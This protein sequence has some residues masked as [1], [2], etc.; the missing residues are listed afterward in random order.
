MM[1]LSLHLDERT[2]RW[3]ILSFFFGRY[4]LFSKPYRT[5]G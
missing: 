1:I 5:H 4:L 2:H 3:E